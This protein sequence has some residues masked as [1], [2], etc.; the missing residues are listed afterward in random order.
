MDEFDMGSNCV[1]IK[2]YET[3]KINGHYRI[4]GRGNLEY[5]FHP[6]VK[7]KTGHGY[8]VI[9]DRQKPQIDYFFTEVEMSEYFIT[10]EMDYKSYLR[11]ERINALIN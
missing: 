7:G 2:E 10:E 6:N 3:L 11:N 9:D 8:C 4:C 5:N 1:C